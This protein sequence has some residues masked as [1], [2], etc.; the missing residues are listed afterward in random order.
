MTGRVGLYEDA[1]SA[2]VYDCQARVCGD[3]PTSKAA[4]GLTR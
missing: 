2:E 4:N 3:T 1:W